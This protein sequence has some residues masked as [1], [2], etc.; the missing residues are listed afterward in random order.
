MGRVIYDQL[1]S[2]GNYHAVKDTQGKATFIRKGRQ[3]SERIDQVDDQGFT[4]SVGRKP[5]LTAS[6]VSEEGK[7][8]HI[9]IIDAKG[10]KMGR[11]LIAW[12]TDAV[13]GERR[14]QVRN[15]GVEISQGYEMNSL[16]IGFLAVIYLEPELRQNW[17]RELYHVVKD[18]DG[19]ETKRGPQI[20]GP[21]Q[22][23]VYA[24]MKRSEIAERSKLLPAVEEY[25]A[26]HVA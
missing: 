6:L 15:R 19:N 11:P 3:A 22:V 14:F 2:T 5:L 23:P 4:I 21:A 7:V 13:T 10:F 24:L 18:E 16:L 9:K 26:E 17:E 25:F 8:P 1:M 20:N 12:E